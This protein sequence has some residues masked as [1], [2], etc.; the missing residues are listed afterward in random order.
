MLEQFTIYEETFLID[1]IT[2]LVLNITL[3]NFLFSVDRGTA[4]PRAIITITI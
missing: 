2:F 3:I 1:G 4:T